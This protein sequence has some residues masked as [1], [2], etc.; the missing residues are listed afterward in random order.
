MNPVNPQPTDRLED[1]LRAAFARAALNAPDRV[2]VLATVAARRRGAA[3]RPHRS[4][5]WLPLVAAIAAVGA[6]VVPLV[7]L[8]GPRDGNHPTAS[9]R[10]AAVGATGVTA[11]GVAATGA[12]TAGATPS[13]ALSDSGPAAVGELCTPAQ[14]S[15]TLAWTASDSA[16]AGSLTATNHDPSACE[17]LVKPIITP[18]AD[19]GTPLGVPNVISE[20]A[21]IGPG[22]L[23]PGA[24]ATSKILWRGSCGAPVHAVQVSW[25]T[26]P[27]TVMA[28]GRSTAPCTSA[29]TESITSNWF[30]PLG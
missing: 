12:P 26:G 9:A 27:V 8:I 1:D 24:S 4:R 21:N 10:N 23:R 18:L 14:V 11:P 2:Q 22:R 13:T 3:G 17:L 15:L 19:N 29:P 28:T 5:R 6:V 16:L 20:E 25:G 7:L 30:S